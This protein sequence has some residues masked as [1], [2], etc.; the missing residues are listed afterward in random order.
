MELLLPIPFQRG[1]KPHLL[2][3]GCGTPGKALANQVKYPGGQSFPITRCCCTLDFR[4]G[5]L[6]IVQLLLQTP[7]AGKYRRG[8]TIAIWLQK[9]STTKHAENCS[10]RDKLFIVA[11]PIQASKVKTQQPNRHD[12][13]QCAAA[14][15]RSGSPGGAM[16]MKSDPQPAVTSPRLTPA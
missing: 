15:I 3:F 2:R 9:K 10:P 8:L 14:S 7:L 1:P 5:L 11:G 4:G 13:C 6:L 16:P 12:L